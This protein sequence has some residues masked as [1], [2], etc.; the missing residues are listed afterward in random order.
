MTAAYTNLNWGYGV[1]VMT[2]VYISG[3]ISGGH[4]NPAITLFLAVFRGFPWKLLWKYWIAQILGAFLGSFIVYGMYC[5]NLNAID[6]RKT[7][8]TTGTASLFP[9]VPDTTNTSVGLAVY[10]EIAATGVLTAS[11]LALGDRDNTPPGASL[12]AF[13]LALIIM[14]IGTS[15]GALSG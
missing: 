12:G 1:G 2:G 7:V 8:S 10:Q 4:L 13:I 9:T 3:G 15:L 5:D 14:A 11:V 6:P